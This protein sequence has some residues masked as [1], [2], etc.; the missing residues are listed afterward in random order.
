[1]KP[2]QALKQALAGLLMAISPMAGAHAAYEPDAAERAVLDAVLHDELAAFL[3]AD[4]TLI[5]QQLGLLAVRAAKLSQA[6][7]DGLERPQTL[8]TDKDLLVGG[9]VARPAPPAVP[10]HARIAFE[11]GATPPV[12]AELSTELP[13]RMPAA[14]T[15]ALVCKQLR[16]TGREFLFS[17]CKDAAPIA[18][19]AVATLAREL[20][21]FFAG[22]P[23][24]MWVSQLAINAAMSAALLPT[25]HGCPQDRERC[26]RAI[27]ATND[28]PGRDAMLRHVVQ[29]Y[30]Q[31]G[32]DLS[33]YEHA[34]R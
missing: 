2:I 5:G 13:E 22:K 1:M 16:W 26:G 27:A 15:L 17:E 30:R 34:G 12:L 25:D 21:D 32:L 29:R 19:Q 33:P 8:S 10:Q 31:A 7:P 9:D 3:K 11:T 18:E 20:D 4:G 24:P 28:A 23:T 14:P 6:Y